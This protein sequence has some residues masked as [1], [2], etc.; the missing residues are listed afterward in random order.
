MIKSNS[1]FYKEIREFLD[2][3]PVINTHEHYT[4]AVKPIE[5]IFGSIFGYY[6]SDCISS[7]FGMEKE[8]S[9]IFSEGNISFDDRYNIFEKAYKKSNKTSYARAMLAGLEA[10]WGIGEINHESIKL[11]E[12][13]FTGRDEAFYVNIMERFKIKSQIANIYNLP[14]FKK[15]IEGKDADY[16]RYCKF[17]FPLPTFHDIKSINDI[18]Q[19]EEYVERKIHCLDDYLEGFENFLGKSIRFGITS[20]KDQCA[21][22]R[23]INFSN[24]CR[25]D[26]EK[27]FN[28]IISHPRDTFGTD[29]VRALDDWLFHYFIKLAQK[30]NL[31]VQI[32]TGHMAGIR[33]DITKTNAAHFIPMLELYPDVKFALF[34]G[35]WPYM[36]EY[37]F[38]G[39]NY[40][41]A[42]LDLCW[43]Q[44]IDPLYSIELMKRALVTVPHSKIMAFGG[45]TYTIEFTA[46]YLILARDN[47]AC[48]LSEMVDSGWINVSEAKEIA[49]D[50][51]FNNP[52]EFYN[53]GYQRFEA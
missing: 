3:V 11:L 49:A 17:A 50:W 44:S 45:D 6:K 29:E 35:N 51:F 24:P 43:V 27:I 36:G 7:A 26:A 14:D 39:K 30:N 16:S 22:S 38:I 23:T 8:T 4:G 5:N 10:C 47:T 33:N 28:K 20:M 40:P 2:T 18:L 25:A 48:A 41:N 12:E 42:Y 37:L 19:V 34:H 46:G 31:P 52:N 21:Y 9:A 32:H 13:K 53:L 1:K 15:I